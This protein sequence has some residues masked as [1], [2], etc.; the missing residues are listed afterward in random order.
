MKN[1]KILIVLILLTLIYSCNNNNNTK[2]NKEKKSVPEN[3]IINIDLDAI[4]KNDTLK[5]LT[6]YSPTSYFLY[7]G[8]VMG[9]EYDILKAVAKKLGVV[10]SIRVAE[11]MDK[12]FE[13]L[14]SG[15]ADIIAYGLTITKDRREIV[16]FTKPYLT[17]HQVLIQK[18]NKDKITDI[19]SLAGKHISVRKESSY[20]QRIQNISE[21][22]GSEIFIDTI[23]GKFSTE[24][25]IEMVNNGNIDYTIA[26]NNLAFVNSTY[27]HDLDMSMPL[28]LGQNLAWA[29][30]KNSPELIKAIN[31]LI[32]QYV[33]KKDFNIIY[34]KYFK[35]KRR[36]S[37]RIK[38]EYYSKNTGEI[39]KYDKLIK[40]YAS[41]INWDWRLLA[42][43]I[44]QESRF[45]EN[46]R[47]W[48]G[49]GGLMQL[50]PRTAKSLGIHNVH[51]PEQNI[52]GGTKYLKKLWGKWDN[53]PDSIQRI[54]FTLASYNCGYY[55]VKDA[56][57]LA[58]ALNKD[59]NYWDNQV[60]GCILKLTKPEYYNREGIYYGYV[61]G[62]EPFNYVLD[63]FYRYQIYK[64]LLD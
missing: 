21:E 22:I 55:H 32:D 18:D 30:R 53:I 50:M 39:S 15:E 57:N 58:I 63:I 29:A 7:K 16:T 61:R 20:F 43:L 31:K 4:V 6:I 24:E 59:P 46:N 11:D 14:N 13:M 19:S 44:Y 45:D 40:K 42:S 17:V 60:D 52:K 35:N 33:R 41:K 38:S 34:N 25:I 12:M 5:A 37:K 1:I 23:D 8:E 64:D 26:D 2:Q 48:A 62:R 3:A 51:N 28:S 36:F 49:A 47:S 27:Y 10:L 54:K 9:F 56:Q